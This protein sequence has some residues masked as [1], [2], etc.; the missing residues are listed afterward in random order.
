M[1]RSSLNCFCL[2]ADE[3]VLA[4]IKIVRGT[5]VLVPLCRLEVQI[6]VGHDFNHDV[7]VLLLSQVD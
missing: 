4:A 7:N 6:H 3:A 1:R 2:S 5:C